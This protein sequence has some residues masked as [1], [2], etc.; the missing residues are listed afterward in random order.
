MK[1]LRLTLL[2]SL[3]LSTTTL[4]DSN[5]VSSANVV[6][7]VAVTI[8]SNSFFLGSC[9]FEVGTTNLFND[10]FGTNQ[11]V[12]GSRLSNCE[13]VYLWD[14]SNQRYDQ[15]AQ[16][17]G[18]TYSTGDWKGTPVNPEVSGGFFIKSSSDTNHVITL[19]GDVVMNQTLPVSIAGG[20]SYTLISYPFSSDIAIS[21][22][23][24]TGA[25]A[26]SRLSNAD[27]IYTWDGDN[28]DQYALYTDGKWYDV[29]DWRGTP[30]T[31]SVNLGQGFW[32]KAQNPITW[33]ATN[34][35]YDT[36]NN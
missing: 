1:I 14:S 24:I 13:I 36:I 26:G 9:S 16:Y 6:G 22:L 20:D 12:S 18:K 25:T 2:L 34:I 15:Y 28:Y 27:L 30:T 4:A 19:S 17:N 7:Y 10:V 11:L 5:V 32:Y 31:N 35:Y 33:S 21:N 23:N 8:P 29:N 3:M